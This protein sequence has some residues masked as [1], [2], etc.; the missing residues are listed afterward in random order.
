MNITLDLSLQA[1]ANI[2]PKRGLTAVALALL[3]LVFGAGCGKQPR[4]AEAKPV[5]K[6]DLRAQLPGEVTG[7]GLHIPWVKRDP[8]HPNGPPVPVLIA[9]AKSGVLTNDEENPTVLLRDARVRLFRNGKPAAT[10]D[11]PQITA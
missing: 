2:V 3:L 8:E 10:I 1:A 4:G 11:A 7:F 5:E 6:K 9:D